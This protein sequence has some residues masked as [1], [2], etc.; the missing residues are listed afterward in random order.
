MKI[1]ESLTE[2]VGGTPLVWLKRVG[3]SQVSNEWWLIFFSSA[4]RIRS[5]GF[6]VAVTV[7][8]DNDIPEL[9]S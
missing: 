6:A 8:V 3:L 7:A 1:A 2:L 9:F 4:A 5:H